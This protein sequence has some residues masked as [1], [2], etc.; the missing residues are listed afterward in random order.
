[1]RLNPERRTRI[2][3]TIR[4]GGADVMALSPKALRALRGRAVAMIF[5]EPLL[6]LDP[7]YTVGQQI[8]EAIR[9]HERIRLRSLCALNVQLNEL[10]NHL[11]QHAK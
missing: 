5:Q 9:Q 1:M 3:G 4:V 6:A 2:G 11:T 10:F 7:V 8:T